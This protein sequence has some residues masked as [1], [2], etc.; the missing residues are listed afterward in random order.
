MLFRHLRKPR[1][2]RLCVFLLLWYLSWQLALLA[3]ALDVVDVCGIVQAKIPLMPGALDALGTGG[4]T[5]LSGL[6]CAVAVSSGTWVPKFH[7][8]SWCVWRFCP[9]TFLTMLLESNE[10][11]SPACEAVPLVEREK[12]LAELKLFASD[13]Q[14]FRWW[15][16][17]GPGGCGKTKLA[18]HFAKLLRSE[19]WH[20][21]FLHARRDADPISDGWKPASDTFVV[22][23]DAARY[24]A[25]VGAIIEHLR[26]ASQRRRVCQVRCLLV[27]QFG[28]AE[29]DELPAGRLAP[30]SFRAEPLKVARF[31]NATTAQKM[32]SKLG[33]EPATVDIFDPLEAVWAA[34]DARA[35]D[36][37]GDTADRHAKRLQRD[38]AKAKNLGLTDDHIH[39][40]V[41]ATFAG[42][43]PWDRVP[44][45]MH[46]ILAKYAAHTADD[47]RSELPPLKPDRLGELLVL[48]R[49]AR[50]PE[51]DR[52]R[53]LGEGW[54]ISHAGTGHTLSRLFV[55]FPTDRRV[56]VVDVPPW[57]LEGI[58][59]ASENDAAMHWGQAHG[60]AAFRLVP[61]DPMQAARH[62]ERLRSCAQAHP[63]DR[64]PKLALTGGAFTATWQCSAGLEGGPFDE[65]WGVLREVAGAVS[66]DRTFRLLL[67]RGA[68]NAVG[69]YGKAKRP[70]E[71][72]AVWDVLRLLGGRFPADMECQLSLAQGAVN[73]ISSYDKAKR[74]NEMDTAWDVLR[75]VAGRFPNDRECQL[76]FAQGAFNA[77][78]AYGKAKRPKEMHTAWDMLRS[79]AARFQKVREFQ[80]EL[81]KG[82]VNALRCCGEAKRGREI[83]A[84]WA[85]L[86]NVAGRFA[87]DR[88]FQLLLAQGTANA[89]S[90]YGEDRRSEEMDAAWGILREVTGHFP[91]DREFQL[92]CAVGAGRAVCHYGEADRPE[93]L[94]AAWHFLLDVAGRFSDD[95]ELQLGLAGGAVNAVLRYGGAM[96]SQEMDAAWAILRQ[97]ARRFTDDREFQLKLAT[98]AVNAVKH[99]GNADRLEEM[100][101]AWNVLQDVSGCFNKDVEFQ[102]KLAKGTANAVICYGTAGRMNELDAAWA[103]SLR[104]SEASPSAVAIQTVTSYTMAMAA[105]FSEKRWGIEQVR[106]SL[107]HITVDAHLLP[108]TD[109]QREYLERMRQKYL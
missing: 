100:G 2:V 37:P 71:M 21:G 88:E 15:W 72:D 48:D 34:L 54:S 42:G 96:R 105:R 44:K 78:S 91:T 60:M 39:W 16:L 97:V 74:S 4:I 83:D 46:T 45:D 93:D 57:E 69:R 101:A 13:G 70:K 49:L 103:V 28:A 1:I 23:D 14:G 27:D 67:A 35:G 25:E 89:V 108:L 99:Y 65:A 59:V 68:V 84:T 87:G 107:Y 106:D 6:L 80:L 104:I 76:T 36:T 30:H 82:A 81:A 51:S 98:G 50:L 7:L 90:R 8:Y 52:Y 109:L 73:A 32:F 24:P 43:L 20:T 66:V 94:D 18:W 56:D 22:I 75:Q 77:V 19:G 102:L 11:D 47:S 79:V 61:E 3:F 33:V 29:L 5:A 38:I 26:S 12:Q 63:K 64:L 92:S 41:V 95:R 53:A 31:F 86:R 62:W 17:R 9:P 58:P 85:V 40:L 55:N 10:W